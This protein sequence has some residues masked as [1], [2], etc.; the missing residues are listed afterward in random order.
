MKTKLYILTLLFA[1]I[2]TSVEARDHRRNDSRKHYVY[3]QKSNAYRYGYIPN[4]SPKQKYQ[5]ENI[6]LDRDRKLDKLN[7]EKREIAHRIAQL[8]SSRNYNRRS[9]DKLRNKLYNIDKEI[10]KVNY[11]ADDKIYSLLSHNQR[12]VYASAQRR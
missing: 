10:N 6:C 3:S 1:T 7:F 4:L 2:F 5:I 11:K 9:V 12:T 8:Q